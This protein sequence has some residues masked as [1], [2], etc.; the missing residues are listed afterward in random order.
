MSLALEALLHSALPLVSLALKDF[1][2]PDQ[3]FI[4][5]PVGVLWLGELNGDG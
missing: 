4:N 1:A 5:D 2:L 3:A